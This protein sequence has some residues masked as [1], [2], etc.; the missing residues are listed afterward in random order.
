VSER[1]RGAGMDEGTSQVGSAYWKVRRLSPVEPDELDKRP[2]RG[3]AQG[4]EDPAKCTVGPVMI[5]IAGSMIGSSRADPAFLLVA[6]DRGGA[7][8]GARR[9]GVTGKRP[10]PS[11]PGRL[12]RGTSRHDGVE[13][14]GPAAS[15]R[16]VENG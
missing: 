2:V 16:T 12:W 7:N 5:L 8:K 11:R 15:A 9:P 6:W 13:G 10:V 4:T 3:G 14:K 1:A